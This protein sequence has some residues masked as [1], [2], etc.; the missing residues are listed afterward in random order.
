MKD[1]ARYHPRAT[2]VLLRHGMSDSNEDQRFGGWHDVGLSPRGIE[3]AR[4]AGRLLD[5]MGVRFDRA[6][7]SVLRRAIWTQRHCLD[8]LGQSWVPATCDW[9]FNERHYGA[10]QGLSKPTAIEMHGEE[11]VRSWRRDFDAWPP[12][13]SAGDER[14]SYG[15]V[16]Y[17][18]LSRSQVPLGESLRATQARVWGAWTDIVAPALCRGETVLLVAHGNSIRSLMMVL[19]GISETDIPL[20]EIPHAVPL[21]YRMTSAGLSRFVPPGAVS[22]THLRAHET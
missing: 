6:L 1:F 14:D 20:V 18:G 9:R 15:K 12:A 3:Q 4:A 19:E 7:S 13:L 8:E 10:L 2:L 17:R 11:Q 5:R 22:Y 21:F 16:Q